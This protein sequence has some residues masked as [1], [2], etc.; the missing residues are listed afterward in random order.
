M[1]HL[2]QAVTICRYLLHRSSN[3]ATCP[4]IALQDWL[5]KACVTEGPPVDN[6][7][8]DENELH[9]VNRI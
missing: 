7:E 2:D 1:D 5:E 4:V 8:Q 9:E 6:M 3:P